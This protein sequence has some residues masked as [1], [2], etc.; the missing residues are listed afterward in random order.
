MQRQLLML[1]KSNSQ[2]SEIKK[3]ACTQRCKPVIFLSFCKRCADICQ[4]EVYGSSVTVGSV[5][6]HRNAYAEINT[7]IRRTAC[8]HKGERDA[9]AGQEHKA[10]TDVDYCLRTNHKHR[11]VAEKRACEIS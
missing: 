1:L 9:D 8:A 10:H 11:A 3:Q 4:A 6:T 5:N 7:H 2:Y